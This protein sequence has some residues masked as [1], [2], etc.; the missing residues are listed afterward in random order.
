MSLAT[1]L[2]QASVLALLALST[3]AVNRFSPFESIGMSER[4]LS[5]DTINAQCRALKDQMAQVNISYVV[6]TACNVT[7]VAMDGCVPLTPCQICREFKTELNAH[8]IS[9]KVLKDW[10]AQSQSQVTVVS[11]ALAANEMEI[12]TMSSTNSTESSSSSSSTSSSASTSLSS[13]AGAVTVVIVALVALVGGVFIVKRHRQHRLEEEALGTP[14]DGGGM[15]VS[16]QS[17]TQIATI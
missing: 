7:K 5:S 4:R 10:K 6:E 11:S 14:K 1:W 17:R 3:V 15:L 8:L 13:P 2:L 12:Q 16:V 9:C